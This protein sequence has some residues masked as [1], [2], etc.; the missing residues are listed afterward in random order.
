M[1]SL[2]AVRIESA[3]VFDSSKLSAAKSFLLFGGDAVQMSGMYG[4]VEVVPKGSVRVCV[5]SSS[6]RGM[7]ICSS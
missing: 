7:S 3:G 4:P 2:A 5:R 6:L 1:D